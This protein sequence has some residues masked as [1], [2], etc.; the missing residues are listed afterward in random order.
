[1]LSTPRG[2]LRLCRE[3]NECKIRVTAT[4]S[5]EAVLA[6]M[7]WG[8]TIMKTLTKKYVGS[9]FNATSKTAGHW[10]T[11]YGMIDWRLAKRLLKRIGFHLKEVRTAELSVSEQ[12]MSH[13]PASAMDFNL[14]ARKQG[15]IYGGLAL[16]RLYLINDLLTMDPMRVSHVVHFIYKN[17]DSYRVL[18]TPTGSSKHVLH[19]MLASGVPF[20]FKPVAL[21][22]KECAAVIRIDVSSDE[23]TYTCSLIPKSYHTVLYQQQRLI[24]PSESIM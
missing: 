5:V 21:Y 12:M 17:G 22:S 24:V 18:Y 14:R 23:N 11:P 7:T 20:R 2:I 1:M 3:N 10:P 4:H 19:D 15:G 6:H 16:N 8:V 9:V 13:F